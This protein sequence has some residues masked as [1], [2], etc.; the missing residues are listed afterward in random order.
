MKRRDKK[1]EIDVTNEDDD[2]ALFRDS[3]QDVIPLR[4]PDKI[5][6][7]RKPIRPIRL[8]DQQPDKQLIVQDALSDHISFEIADGDEW[9]FLRPGLS[10]QTLRRLR[11]G[12]WGIQAY[13]DL[14]GF[15]SDEAR[16]ALVTFLNDSNINNFRCVCIIHGKG[17]SSKNREPVIKTRIGNWLLQREDIL[18]FCQAKPKDGGSGALL[19]LL[20]SSDKQ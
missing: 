6:H 1:L 7:G 20:K 3:M 2:L 11:R 14:H 8:G 13:L 4:A 18:A 9:S 19:V 5:I 12:H 16:L 15:T 17:L 10:R